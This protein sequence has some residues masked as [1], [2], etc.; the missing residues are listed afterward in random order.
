MLSIQVKG[1]KKDIVAAV[2]K[3][4]FGWALDRDNGSILWS[5]EAGP[6]SIGGGTWGAATDEKRIYTNIWQVNTKQVAQNWP[7]HGGDLY[8][9]R[10]ANKEKKISPKTM[11]KL[12]PK[13]KFYAGGDISVTPAIFSDTVLFSN[14]EWKPLCN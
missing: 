11:S 8:N 4:G 6:G 3:S 12:H 10:Y 1:M 5:T 7:N 13:W 9:R 14:L 2:Q